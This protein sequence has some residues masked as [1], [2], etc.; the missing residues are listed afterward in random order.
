MY[1]GQVHWGYICW[2]DPSTAE[3]GTTSDFG[4]AAVLGL[5]YQSQTA[6]GT[7]RCLFVVLA[8][9]PLLEHRIG[10]LGRS[11]EGGDT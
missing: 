8:R 9:Q 1:P 10:L 4:H 5:N 6:P 2:Q 11:W 3:G 7:M